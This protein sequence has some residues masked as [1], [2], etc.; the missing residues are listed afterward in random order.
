[1]K[2]KII[3]MLE[4][5][6]CVVVNVFG[7]IDHNVAMAEELERQINVILYFCTYLIQSI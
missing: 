3:Q 6:I 1:M 7:G 5:L 2:I 4:A